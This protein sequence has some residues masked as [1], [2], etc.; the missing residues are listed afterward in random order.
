MDDK[1]C[2]ASAASVLSPRRY[3]CHRLETK[4]RIRPGPRLRHNG[5]R[6]VCDRPV[7][8]GKYCHRRRSPLAASR[9]ADI[10]VEN[11]TRRRYALAGKGQ[12]DLVALDRKCRCIDGDEPA[13]VLECARFSE[14]PLVR[15]Y[16]SAGNPASERPVFRTRR[17]RPWILVELDMWA[18]PG[19]NGNGS[20]QSDSCRGDGKRS[21]V[22]LW[23]D[24]LRR[25]RGGCRGQRRVHQGLH[26]V[27]K[28]VGVQR[29]VDL[30]LNRGRL[31]V[32]RI[33]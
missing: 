10:L 32:P 21:V 7:D 30:L 11:R 14:V 12:A 8:P 9:R 16:R 22:E 24:L 3:M 26:Q 19:G 23:I 2:S 13:R 31:L 20:T 33:V 17:R 6:P 5:L 18:G 1:I 27:L 4:L 25:V 28:S 15:F 29:I